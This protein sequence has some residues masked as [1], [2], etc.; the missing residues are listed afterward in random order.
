MPGIPKGERKMTPAEDVASE[1]EKASARLTVEKEFHD[2]LFAEGGREAA[3]R[4]YIVAGAAQR[5]YYELIEAHGGQGRDVLQLGCGTGEDAMRLARRG[6]RVVGVDVSSEGL[7]R[8]RT[9]AR[10]AGLGHNTP[11][12]ERMNG[13]ALTFSD[14]RFDLVIGGGI[15][16]HL[17][18]GT[19]CRELP[20]VLR[21]GG[22]AIFLEPLG[23][24]PLINLYRRLTPTMR[25]AHEH[26]LRVTDL[27][28]L[29][30]PFHEASYDYHV[31]CA[32][33][34][35]PLQG[36]PGFGRILNVAE[37]VDAILLSLP[38]VKRMAWQVVVH[39][40]GPHTAPA[41]AEE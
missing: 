24:N 16:H 11:V 30:Q 41:L 25:L 26:P 5:R 27:K 34:T 38:F 19:M 32:L 18:L 40:A 37:R 22:R 17:D 12:F 9:R 4:F 7:R 33:A 35:V 39:L 2:R 21:T 13:E 23:H 28:M 15:L 36:V 14:A 20:R 1:E 10:E 31:M 8:A 29:A 6:A 3:N